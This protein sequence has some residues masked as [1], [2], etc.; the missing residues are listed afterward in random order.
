[1]RQLRHAALG[2]GLALVATGLRAQDVTR[3]LERAV[4]TY[5][6]VRSLRAAF[7]Q[8]ITNPMIGQPDSSR[9]RLFLV[10]PDRFAMRFSSP[11]GDR[12]VVD[13]RWLWLYLPSTVPDQVVRAAVPESGTAGPNLFA[14]FLDR[15]SERYRAT[16]LGEIRIGGMAHDLV[17]LVPN[18]DVGF[19]S[20][21]LAIG[22]GDGLIRMVDLIER[23]GLSRRIELS[24]LEVNVEIPPAELRFS[25]PA[26]AR[27]VTQP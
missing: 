5:G 14:Q 8:T 26:G 19:R 27:I 17:Q 2:I 6:S 25:P 10:R 18:E 3:A 22:Q 7:V 4:T 1:M 24:E 23:S 20:A 21:E 16:Y 12:I 15:P 9:G 11:A 13:R